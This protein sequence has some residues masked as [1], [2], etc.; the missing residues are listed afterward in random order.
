MKPI[1]HMRSKRG[2]YIGR[3]SQEVGKHMSSSKLSTEFAGKPGGGMGGAFHQLMTLD[4][5][6]QKRIQVIDPK[7]SFH[8]HFQK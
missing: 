7:A 1:K 5:G 6:H 4:G 2:F 3:L 8:E